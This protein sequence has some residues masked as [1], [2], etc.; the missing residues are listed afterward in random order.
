LYLMLS[1]T[2]PFDGGGGPFHE[3]VA[4]V[5]ERE[6]PPIAGVPGPLW[7][8]L[9]R[10]LAKD[11]TERYADATELGLALRRAAGRAIITEPGLSVAARGRWDS[12]SSVPPIDTGD[13]EG[14]AQAALA[15][16]GPGSPARRG[17]AVV[18]VTAVVS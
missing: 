14:D 5:L 2:N 15:E 1:G 10:A 9:A 11:P 12:A 4:A 3:V 17:R 16:A 6:P 13:V 7:E 8:V 18:V